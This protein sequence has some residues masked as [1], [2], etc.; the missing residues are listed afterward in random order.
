[1]PRTCFLWRSLTH[2][3]NDKNV[4][5]VEYIIKKKNNKNNNDIKRWKVRF[6]ISK[7]VHRILM[8]YK[9]TLLG[10][11]RLL[12]VGIKKGKK[13]TMDFAVIGLWDLWMKTELFD[14]IG[15][16]EIAACKA[17]DLRCNFGRHCVARVSPKKKCCKIGDNRV[18]GFYNLVFH[19]IWGVKCGLLCQVFICS[20][21]LERTFYLWIG[22]W[23]A[24]LFL[25]WE[26]LRNW[27]LT[28]YASRMSLLPNVVLWKKSK[29]IIFLDRGF[30]I[31][32]WKET[33]AW[34]AIIELRWNE[35]LT[36]N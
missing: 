10:D 23:V 11:G 2:L 28:T 30:E 35:R 1:M 6:M 17:L 32:Q 16:P 3:D 27:E 33:Y 7:F 22:R 26:K 4:S 12:A 31:L 14:I 8:I 13:R 15:F 24:V 21:F 9:E 36:L 5:V 19:V 29:K 20:F 18:F 34:T 25:S